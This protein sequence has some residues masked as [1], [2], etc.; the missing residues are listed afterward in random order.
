MA[1]YT[2]KFSPGLVTTII[3]VF[4]LIVFGLVIWH[5]QAGIHEHD[6]VVNHAAATK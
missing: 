2:K 3:L 5:G 4:W 6:N 1:E